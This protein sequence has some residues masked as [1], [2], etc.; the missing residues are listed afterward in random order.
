[1]SENRFRLKYDQ[2]RDGNPAGK[3]DDTTK[4]E[5]AQQEDKKYLHSGHN[6]HLA[7]M[8]PDGKLE[9]FNYAYLVSIKYDPIS[10]PNILA[11]HFTSDVVTI[12]GYGLMPLVWD[13]FNGMSRI[14]ECIDPR[15]QE[16]QDSTLPA[17]TEITVE[18]AG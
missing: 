10:D 18:H 16:T 2:L 13:V 11:L 1:M 14:I 5:T 4:A 9:S 3:D 12:K 6:R 8:W 17:I 7:V 15:Y